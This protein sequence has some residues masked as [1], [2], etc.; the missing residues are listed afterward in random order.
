MLNLRKWKCK[1]DKK[2]KWK[3][4]LWGEI[5]MS[6]STR[7]SHFSFYWKMTL[8]NVFNGKKYI[9]SLLFTTKFTY[10]LQNAFLFPQSTLASHPKPCWITPSCPPCRPFQVITQI[11]LRTTLCLQL[12]PPPA[13]EFPPPRSDSPRP[14]V[15]NAPLPAREGRSRQL[16]QES[17]YAPY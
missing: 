14:P 11:P 13:R 2:L 7:C 17:S 16:P 5:W 1:I 8:K 4:E 6:N 10:S 12:P 15:R 3:S 9:S